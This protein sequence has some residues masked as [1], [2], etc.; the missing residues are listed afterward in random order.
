MPGDGYFVFHCALLSTSMELVTSLSPMA[1]LDLLTLQGVGPRL[2]S[3]SAP[4]PRDDRGAQARVTA[5]LCPPVGKCQFVK[6]V[7]FELK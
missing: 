1:D 6:F 7:G 2:P 4:R 5:A 3:I